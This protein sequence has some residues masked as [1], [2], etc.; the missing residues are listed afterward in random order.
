[1]T[2]ITVKDIAATLRSHSFNEEAH[3]GIGVCGCG[4]ETGTN[5]QWSYEEHAATEIFKTL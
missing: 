1:M 4:W 2:N 5:E 3:Y